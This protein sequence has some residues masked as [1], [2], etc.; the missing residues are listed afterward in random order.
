MIQTIK[1]TTRFKKEFRKVLE[2]GCNPEIFEFVI[3]EL[4]NER[5]LG[6]NFRD[7][8]L[9]GTYTGQRECHLNP[10]WLLIYAIEKKI[11]TLTLRV[12]VHILIY[13]SKYCSPTTL[14][15]LL[16][17]YFTLGSVRT[18]APRAVHFG[19][20]FLLFYHNTNHIL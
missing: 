3:N 17:P 19:Q 8:A 14:K 4:V 11:L 1:R 5:P 9:G 15:L 20:L 7:H 6:E 2:R 12:Q 16:L 10:D 13:S 18:S